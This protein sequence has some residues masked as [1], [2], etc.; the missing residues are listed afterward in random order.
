[1]DSLGPIS[2]DETIG[3]RI[4]SVTKAMRAMRG[5]IAKSIFLEK[6]GV[7]QLSTDSNDPRALAGHNSDSRTIGKR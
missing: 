7:I 1:M 4:F 3:R 2:S 6:A 5:N